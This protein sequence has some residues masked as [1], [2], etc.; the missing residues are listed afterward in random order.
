[1]CGCSVAYLLKEQGWKVVIYE[2]SGVL[3]GGCRTLYYG[4]HPYT[5]G[6]RPL[7]TPH[8]KVYD[9][10]SEFVP[11]RTFP[12]Y[13]KTF[14]EQDSAFY[15]YPVHEDDV[16]LMPDADVIRKQL[17][18][19][20]SINESMD[21]EE[22]YIASLGQNLYDKFVKY[23]SQKM[24][25]VKSNKELTDF[26]WSVKGVALQKGPRSV[27][28][29]LI[30]GH[31]QN[32]E[33]YNPYFEAATADVDKIH[34]NKKIEKFDLKNKAVFVDGKWDK[35]D[36]LVSTTSVD[37]LFDYEHGKLRYIGR[38]FIP[39]VL[40]VETTIP[41]EDMFLYYAGQES[42]TRIVE[43]KKLYGY[44]SPSTLLGMEV[45]SFKNEM[46]PYPIKSERE[47]AAKYIDALPENVF[48]L[49]RM[50]RYVYD[51]IGQVI[52]QSFELAEKLK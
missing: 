46:Y 8:Q 20:K 9:F 30:I 1:M 33:G 16:D 21:F 22:Y 35:A 44:S 37:R 12:L 32:K 10:L 5:I 36:V 14:V 6:P 11:L 25:G 23:Y 42:F 15:S 13:L 4:G 2:G 47:K 51:N 45:P 18:A 48:S 43:Y 17:A 52:M 7:Y 24:W 29:D 19:D 41:T 31:P 40:P 28:D 50:G 39:F 49:G 3:G 38:E 26:K 34:F 27:C